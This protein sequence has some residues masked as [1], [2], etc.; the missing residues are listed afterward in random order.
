MTIATG[1]RIDQE[2]RLTAAL[3]I[4]LGSDGLRVPGLDTVSAQAKHG[5][6][7]LGLPEL[8]LLNALICGGRSLSGCIEEIAD[9]TGTEA[10]R[11]R[12]L[13]TKLWERGL[14]VEAAATTRARRPEPVLVAADRS[15]TFA[16]SASLAIS[17][18]RLF[19]L[20]GEG[21]E[22]IDHQGRLRA[23]LG[24]VELA[25]ASEF[26][27]AVAVQHAFEA[28]RVSCGRLA[29]DRPAFDDLVR[30]LGAA[31]LLEAVKSQD[32]VESGPD[33]RR[34]RPTFGRERAADR[35]W[36]RFQR[37]NGLMRQ[38]ARECEGAEEAREKRTGRQR[39]KV[40]SVQQNGII[41]PLALGMIVAFA[42]AYDGGRLNEH[43]VFHPDWLIRPAKVRALTQRPGIFLFSNYNW[44]HRHNF[45]VSKKVK[46]LSPWS[47]T[48]HG[49][50]NTPKYEADSEAYFRA[51]PDVDITVR[52]EGE[53]AVAEVLSALVDRVGDGPPDLS[54]LRDVPGISYR[55]GEQVVRTPDRERIVDL[56]AIP[57]PILTGLFDDYEGTE[58]GIVETNRGCPYSCTFCD[59]G[60]AIGSRIRQFSI[61]RVFA[62]LEWCASHQVAG[63]MCA[64]ANFGI[65]ERDVLI[66]EKVAELK[67]KYGYPNGFSVS[68]AKNSTKHTKRIIEI[69]ADSGVMS[70]GS[71][72]VQSTDPQTL[73]TVGRSNI[74]LEKYDE[75]TTEFRRAGLPLWADLMFGLPGQT[76]ASFQN[77]LQG[78]I[79]R[80]V[81]PRMFMTELLVNSPMNEPAYREKHRIRTEASPDGSRQLVV[82]TAT[83]SREDYEDMNGLRLLFMLSD[84]IGMLRHVAH[85]VRSETGAREI[86]FYERLRRDIRDDPER[87]PT[88]AFSVRALPSLLVPPVSWYLL[89]Q[90]ARRYLTEVWG[91]AEDGALDTVLAV[92]HAI[93]P[94]RDRVMPHTIELAHDYAAW[95]QAMVEATQAGHHDDWPS[96]VPKLREFG[97][98]SFTVDDPDQLC[99]LGIGAAVDG[100]LFGNYEL[101]S[102]VSRWIAPIANLRAHEANVAD[103]GTAIAGS[104]SVM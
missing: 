102:P 56:D 28:H 92:Q 48:V 78:C 96:V 4:M 62:E 64:D 70:K 18:P 80:G 75:L 63:I 41:F 71:I 91:L 30:R 94:A 47:L 36:Q 103:A 61:E 29:L 34:G 66:A 44:S 13:I 32:I 69:L 2:R 98:A 87:W 17:T 72:G 101:R 74:K 73:R 89:V 37:L 93:L 58:L 23:H 12:E 11:L 26:R 20:S 7:P 15:I 9:R 67:E 99:V 43:Y 59:W 51:N 85:Y 84:A 95:H 104:G 83:F 35:D 5:P 57:S 39:V 100:D 90:E 55:N 53:R 52:G 27:Q 77:D 81:F 50:P 19:R 10:E 38:R 3:M 54:V 42:K 79:N 86:D 33:M 45:T 8:L 65:F 68:A 49:G 24:P 21:F 31:E 60:S 88:I 97:P 40:V 14:L 25:A 76:V 22:H 16:A 46:Q 1:L 82:A 6:V